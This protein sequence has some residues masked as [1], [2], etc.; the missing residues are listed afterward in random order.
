MT[1]TPTYHCGGPSER[2]AAGCGATLTVAERDR[3][4]G[5]GGFC[6]G[7]KPKDGVNPINGG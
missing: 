1:T 7:C 5:H 3:A 6:F 2:I 4:D